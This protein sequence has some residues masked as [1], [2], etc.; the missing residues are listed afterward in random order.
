[1]NDDLGDDPGNPH[2]VGPNQGP[3]APV[4]LKDYNSNDILGGGTHSQPQVPNGQ[5]ITFYNQLG[6]HQLEKG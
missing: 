4:E 2:S 1:M 5:Y 6:H 3:P